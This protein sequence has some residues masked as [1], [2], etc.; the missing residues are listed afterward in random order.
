MLFNGLL[1]AEAPVFEK[2]QMFDIAGSLVERKRNNFL[3]TGCH[4]FVCLGSRKW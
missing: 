3:Y 4:K 1:L 2:T